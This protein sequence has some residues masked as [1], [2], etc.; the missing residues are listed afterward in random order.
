MPCRLTAVLNRL[1]F[2]SEPAYLQNQAAANENRGPITSLPERQFRNPDFKYSDS[3]PQL[4]TSSRRPAETASQGIL[5]PQ[6]AWGVEHIFATLCGMRGVL[7]FP[8][9]RQ[10][11]SRQLGYATPLP[12]VLKRIRNSS[13]A[14]YTHNS[15]TNLLAFPPISDKSNLKCAACGL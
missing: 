2:L 15:V 8:L 1:W 12:L 4:K 10:L 6:S 11:A 7:P 3:E 9:V 5:I 14:T 13:A